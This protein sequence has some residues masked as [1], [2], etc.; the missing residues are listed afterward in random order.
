MALGIIWVLV[1]QI[2]TNIA[3]WLAVLGCSLM[4]F[5]IGMIPLLDKELPYSSNT[6]ILMALVPLALMVFL[7]VTAC[8]SQR[9]LKVSSV[10]LCH[11]A[12]FLR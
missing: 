6:K 7:S 5:L 3:V 9:Q 12:K 2:C 4:M 11:S 8:F 10:F 1:V